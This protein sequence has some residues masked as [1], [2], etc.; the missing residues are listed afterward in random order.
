MLD[1]DS[2]YVIYEIIKSKKSNLKKFE[3]LNKKYGIKNIEQLC[4]H[5]KEEYIFQYVD[6]ALFTIEREAYAYQEYMAFVVQSRAAYRGKIYK[7]QIMSEFRS[8]GMTDQHRS[9]MGEGTAYIGFFVDMMGG[10]IKAANY[11]VSDSFMGARTEILL[12]IKEEKS[13]EE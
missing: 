2:V 1:H 10:K 4:E 3:E 5:Y 6:E 11:P 8:K 7:E 12:P 9:E 13:Q